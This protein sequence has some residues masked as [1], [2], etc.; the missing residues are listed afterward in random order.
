VR[1]ILAAGRT[2][3]EQIL[4]MNTQ[5]FAGLRRARD[6]QDAEGMV[7]AYREYLRQRG[8][9]YM[10]VETGHRHSDLTPELAE[11][12]M[13]EG[14]AEV[15][16]ELIE[17]LQ[18][19]HVKEMILNV[20]NQGALAG[21]DADDVVEVPALVARDLVRPLAVGSIPDHCLGLM[22]QVKAYER[23]TLTA[24]VQH[25]YAQAVEALALHPLVPDWATA[26]AILDDFRR[27]H[28][29]LFPALQ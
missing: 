26:K 10:S 3:G 5:L 27:E 2:R 6:A 21:F 18:G 1:N 25:S 22:K 13:G 9:T 4:A 8:E 20:P 24:A 14:Y 29:H 12:F 17:G 15:A 7:R 28:G 19:A 23:L 11:A 16:L